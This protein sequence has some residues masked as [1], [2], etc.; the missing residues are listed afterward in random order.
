MTPAAS[1]CRTLPKLSH[2]QGR[3]DPAIPDQ[4]F[5]VSGGARERGSTNGAIPGPP[6]QPRILVRG[7]QTNVRY[8]RANFDLLRRRVLAAA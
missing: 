4:G 5:G 6:G 2:V 1:P 8:G 3:N 7:C